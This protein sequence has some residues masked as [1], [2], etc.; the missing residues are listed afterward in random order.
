M[1]KTWLAL[2]ALPVI[3][4]PA[5]SWYLGK[6][7]QMTLDQQYAQLDANPF[8]KVVE[9]TY[10]RG[11]MS[12][13]ETVTIEVFGDMMRSMAADMPEGVEAPEPLRLT[14][15]S[16]IS[17]GPF[18]GGLSAAVIDSE[19]VVPESAAAETKKLFGD[20]KPLTAHTVVKFDGSG[21]S[22]VSS[23]ALSAPLPAVDGAEPGHMAWQGLDVTIGFAADLSSYTLDGTAPK[24]EIRDGNGVHMVMTGMTMAAD[25]RRVFEDDPFLYAGSQRFTLESMAISGPEMEGEPVTLKDIRY[26]IDAP[27][28]GDFLDLSAKMSANVVQVGDFNFGPAHYD[29]S[30]E[31]LHARTVS[32][33]YS[34]MMSLYS[35]PSVFM[36]KGDPAVAMSALAGPAMAL[37]KH[38]P[39]LKLDRLSFNTPSGE[40]MVN[41]QASV[42]GL[43]PEE[44]SNPM[45][46]LGKLQASGNLVLP[47]QMMREMMLNRT[48][49]QLAMM[50]PE[51]V[52]SE[53]QVAMVNAQL[54]AQLQQFESL[55][56]IDRADGLI[57]ARFAFSQGQLTVND[58]P[59]NP[60]Q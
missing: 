54:D 30:M 9:R 60:N 57:K 40:A 37:L 32:E 5:T 12:A 52:L 13:N 24:L 59:F 49:T 46:M 35:D 58:K 11:L 34:A 2:L 38:D 48:Q 22:D 19:L 27:L 15:Y 41:A 53:E 39:V 10:E 6:Q 7:V 43:A 21:T 26:D 36:G 1:K 4:Y 16:A 8:V 20:A 42:P 28:K 31:H 18:V 44:M 51:A 23:P 14:F 55:G 47:E 17:H 56:Y 29:F 33:L 50:D 45:I 3:A 25:Q